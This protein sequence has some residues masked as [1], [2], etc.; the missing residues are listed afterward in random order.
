M[1]RVDRWFS[2]VLLLVGGAFLSQALQLPFWRGANPGTGMFPTLASLTLVLVSG[3]ALVRSVIARD[4]RPSPKGGYWPARSGLRSQAYGLG[5]VVA[6]AL[7]LEPLGFVLST[8]MFLSALLIALE[9]AKRISLIGFA[10][11][12][13]AGAYLFLVV[14]LK[15]PMPVGLFR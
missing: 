3:L 7:L 12:L 1:S 15:M 10:G 2:L 4:A 5:S 13:S 6:Y 11:L 8:F 14:L 9:P